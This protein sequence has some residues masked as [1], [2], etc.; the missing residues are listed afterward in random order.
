MRVRDLSKFDPN[1]P[2]L[3]YINNILTPDIIQVQSTLKKLHALLLSMPN[4]FDQLKC[5]S[6]FGFP[7]Y[8]YYNVNDSRFWS[9][10]YERKK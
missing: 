8:H 4:L 9:P 2:W 3:D 1:T 5:C 10:A 7:S 6:S